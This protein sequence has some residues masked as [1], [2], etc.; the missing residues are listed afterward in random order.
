MTPERSIAIAFIKQFRENMDDM[1]RPLSEAA[2]R[3]RHLEESLEPYVAYQLGVSEGS[4]D[5][6]LLES[7]KNIVRKVPRSQIEVR[8]ESHYGAIMMS[9][10]KNLWNQTAEAACRCGLSLPRHEVS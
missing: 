5:E 2:D 3:E 8:N 6:E 4:V 7:I 9:Q 1:L 10:P